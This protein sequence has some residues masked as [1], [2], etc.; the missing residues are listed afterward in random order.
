MLTNARHPRLGGALPKTET[1]AVSRPRD[2]D[3]ERKVT[4][5]NVKKL[6]RTYLVN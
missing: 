5:A 3:G 4:K 2:G 1:F 6:L